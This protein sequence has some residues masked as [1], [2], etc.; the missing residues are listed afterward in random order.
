MLNNKFIY[1]LLILTA[2]LPAQAAS[3]QAL[4]Q[5]AVT[6]AKKVTLKKAA[7]AALVTTAVG[8]GVRR[9]AKSETGK[10]QIAA[11]RK[12]FNEK[13][14]IAKHIGPT[15][16]I[17]TGLMSSATYS[18]Y[19]KL[20]LAAKLSEKDAHK[21]AGGMATLVGGLLLS[22][23]WQ[24]AKM[25]AGSMN[26]D[27]ESKT[28]IT[29][30]DYKGNVPRDVLILVDQLKHPE[31]HAKLRQ[32]GKVKL[33][34]GFLLYGAPGTGKTY[35]ARAVAG[36]LGVPFSNIKVTDI[37]SSL[38]GASETAIKNRFAALRAVAARHP[39]KM[40]VM[41][42]D[43]IDALGAERAT[44]G[45]Y[46]NPVNILQTLLT[47]I[48]GFDQHDVQ[49][50]VIGATNRT[51]LVDS[52]LKRPG[53]LY[54][55]IEIKPLDKKGCKEVLDYYLSKCAYEHAGAE[56]SKDALLETIA[57]IAMAAGRA[58]GEKQG[59]AALLEQL[60]NQAVAE[61]GIQNKDLVTDAILIEEARRIFEGYAPDRA[62]LHHRDEADRKAADDAMAGLV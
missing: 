26:S 62:P 4:M 20:M 60:V 48:D 61:A 58:A 27:V 39:K 34:K 33:N 31:K 56:K 24:Q 1:S 38:Y 21:I 51:E 50:V 22:A 25:L 18:F 44:T 47:E 43:E 17:F 45:N 11:V 10:K 5:P 9:Y 6:M 41:F 32:G 59:T 13:L 19:K 30:K 8:V 42:I 3:M 14:H 2:C 16:V 29:L 36:S 23:T 7:A 28:D 54:P 35:L 15:G 40:G 49:I 37:K 46:N 12:G 57:D 55:H 53:R 52:A